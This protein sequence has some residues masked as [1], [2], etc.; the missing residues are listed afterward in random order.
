MKN[1]RLLH[2]PHPSGVTFFCLLFLKGER[3][4]LACCCCLTEQLT[5]VCA[6]QLSSRL[7]SPRSERAEYSLP[8]RD[9]T[10]CAT[11]SRVCAPPHTAD[12]SMHVNV[13]VSQRGHSHEMVLRWV[14]RVA[15]NASL[16]DKARIGQLMGQEVFDVVHFP[17]SGAGQT[18]SIGTSVQCDAMRSVT[19]S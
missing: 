4:L 18:D 9:S 19:L 7:P 1:F 6:Q 12:Q 11:A 15:A 3:L 8:A 16:Q 10:H 17:S 14:S 2:R 13:M 5:V